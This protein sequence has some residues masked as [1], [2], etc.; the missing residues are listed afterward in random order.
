MLELKPVVGSSEIKDVTST[1]HRIAGVLSFSS[2][3]KLRGKVNVVRSRIESV[4]AVCV[5]LAGFVEAVSCVALA[6][7]VPA[8]MPAKSSSV[9]NDLPPCPK[10]GDPPLYVAGHLLQCFQGNIN[11]TKVLI[12]SYYLLSYPEYDDRNWL[13]KSAVNQHPSF[14]NSITELALLVKASNLR[15]IVTEQDATDNFNSAKTAHPFYY[16]TWMTIGIE[17]NKFP[18]NGDYSDVKKRMLSLDWRG[19]FEAP[20]EAYGL[21]YYNSSR[22]T[23]FDKQFLTGGHAEIFVQETTNNPLIACETFRTH[24]PPFDYFSQCNHRF[25]IVDLKSVVDIT[26]SKKDIV[27][28]REIQDGVEEII[29]SLIVR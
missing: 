6:D 29:R 10:K 22:T 24:V 26:Y 25:L 12:P 8:Q 19:P 4:I 14:A 3:R 13:S 20:K 11:G 1:R 23:D 15:P 28:W 9:T 16:E 18:L 2:L 21:Q 7:S 17:A 27:R 5:A